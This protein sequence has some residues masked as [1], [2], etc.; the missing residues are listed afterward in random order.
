MSE[1]KSA[2][3]ELVTRS[4]PFCFSTAENKSA[5]IELVTRSEIFY[6]STSG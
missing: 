4:V 2:P 3:I 1:N 5:P 6:F